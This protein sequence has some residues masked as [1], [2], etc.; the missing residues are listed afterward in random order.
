MKNLQFLCFTDYWWECSLRIVYKTLEHI[1][2]DSPKLCW[3]CYDVFL[4][5]FLTYNY[6]RKPPIH[7]D[8]GSIE[9]LQDGTKFLALLEVLSGERLVCHWLISMSSLGIVDWRIL[10]L[11]HRILWVFGMLV[12]YFKEFIG[13]VDR[14]RILQLLHGILWLNFS[15]FL[16]DLSIKIFLLLSTILLLFQFV[17]ETQW[18]WGLVSTGINIQKLYVDK[19]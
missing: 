13:I 1:L 19:A 6:Q 4:T 15:C 17:I 11:L 9:G 7:I 5:D 12:T 14:T 18:F 8:D 10:R 3:P 16:R 2:E